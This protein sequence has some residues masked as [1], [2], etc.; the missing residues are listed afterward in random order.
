MYARPGAPQHRAEWSKKKVC[1]SIDELE[2]FER[3]SLLGLAR[4]RH[5][6]PRVSTAQIALCK[7]ACASYIPAD[8]GEIPH[9]GWY[10][11]REWT[12]T[13]PLGTDRPVS[14]KFKSSGRDWCASQTDKKLYE[15]ISQEADPYSIPS[16]LLESAAFEDDSE[17]GT[18]EVKVP[19]TADPG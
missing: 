17:L 15:G 2:W 8:G 10:P 5:G 9:V 4:G 12:T 14:V 6:Q 11:S 18:D 3:F 1:S 7:C 19:F 13:G 16:Q